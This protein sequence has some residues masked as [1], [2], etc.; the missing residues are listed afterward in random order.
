MSVQ[1]HCDNCDAAIAPATNRGPSDYSHTVIHYGRDDSY[2]GGQWPSSRRDF[3]NDLCLGRWAI[4][5]HK[6]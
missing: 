5:R 1:I 6:D 3:C 2:L 4:E